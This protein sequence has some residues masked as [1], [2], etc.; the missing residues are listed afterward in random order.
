MPLRKSE[1]EAVYYTT[2]Q[3]AEALG[4]TKRTLKNWLR[5]G[6][7]TEPERNAMTGYRRWTLRDI[8]NARQLMLRGG[9]D[10]A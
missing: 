4:I 10:Q 5:L 9:K 3:A 2:F 6:K 8:E 7:V 1:R